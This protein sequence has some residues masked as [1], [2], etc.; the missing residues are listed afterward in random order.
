MSETLRIISAICYV[1][2]VLSAAVGIFLFF[3]LKIPDVYRY[4]TGKQKKI[5][6]RKKDLPISEQMKKNGNKIYSMDNR[7]VWNPHVGK[8]NRGEQSYNSDSS[9]FGDLTQD[10]GTRD[11]N[12]EFTQTQGSFGRDTGYQAFTE[13]ENSS[14][15]SYYDVTESD[16]TV[17]HESP[18]MAYAGSA[19]VQHGGFD[20]QDD[21]TGIFE[22]ESTEMSTGL[23]TT[24][25]SDD[26]TVV[27]DMVFIHT[28]EFI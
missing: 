6:K 8:V 5:R 25:F 9:L 15:D 22:D 26:Q 2:A 17:M 13:T 7:P 11:L 3:K 27:E 20:F 4:L 1:L 10:D 16:E 21:E 24:V 14:A 28:E 19:G 18:V 23:E 12:G